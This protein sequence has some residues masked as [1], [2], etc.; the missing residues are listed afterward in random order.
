MVLG[1]LPRQKI[2]LQPKTNTKPNPKPNQREFSSGAI[3][4]LP[5]NPKTNPDLEPR[6]NPKRGQF[7]LGAGGSN[8]LDT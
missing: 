8:C 7:F 5:S 2:A 1:Q 4:W 3:V 6:P